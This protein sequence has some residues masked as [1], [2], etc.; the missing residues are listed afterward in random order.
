MQRGEAESEQVRIITAG[1]IISMSA[2]EPQAIATRGEWI[3][4]AGGLDEL[5]RDFPS[6]AVHDFGPATVVPGF[7]DAHQHPTI[8][9]EQSLQVDLSPQRIGSTGDLAAALRQR[10]ARTPP[11]DWVVGCGYDHF[12]SNAG[13]ELTRADL[14]RACPDHPVLVV[15]VTLHAGVVNT[16]ALELA[17]LTDESAPPAGGEL[18]RDAGGR[19]TGVLHD[20]ALYDLAFPAFTRRRTIVPRPSTDDSAEAFRRYARKLHAA[21]ITSVG[22]ALV[23]PQGWE[24]L[25][26]VEQDDRL[27]LR[28]NALVAHEHFDHFRSLAID[29]PRPGDRLRLGGVKAFADGAVNG[30][31][32]LVEQPIE[33]TDRHGIGRVSPAELDDLVREV[34]EAGWRIGVHANGDRAI[35]RVLD[36]VEK[37][38]S[39]DPRPDMRHRI[40]HCSIV[41]GDLVAR[42]RQHG[43]IAVP[44]GNYVAA[45]GDKL[46]GYYGPQRAER[47]FAHRRLLDAGVAVAGSSD[48]PC[49]PYEPLFALQSCVT[50]RSPDGSSFGATQRITAAEALA[51]YTTGSAYASEEETTKGRLVPGHLADFAVLGEDPLTADAEHLSGIPV[52]ETWVGA[53]PVWSAEQP[54]SV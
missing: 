47:M 20:Q 39:N 48:H 42:M 53:E 6:A 54:D 40:E 41:D 35:R 17:G 49:G 43:L 5:R 9:A 32:C 16:R 15:H 26:R 13:V 27:G 34:H 3:V 11:G 23:G 46:I 50:R 52:L 18:G 24:L 29:P 51:L 10:A 22:D 38:Q 37:A 44:F 30:G 12:R 25:R 36:A 8:C 45:H 21:G 28:V 19:L 1:R 2:R 31:T 33:G 7:N 4:A 14:D